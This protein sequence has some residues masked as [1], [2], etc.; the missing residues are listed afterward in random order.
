MRVFGVVRHPPKASSMYL[1]V[2]LVWVNYLRLPLRGRVDARNLATN[3]GRG[4][5]SPNGAGE[6]GFWSRDFSPPQNCP[7]MP[8]EVHFQKRLPREPV[9]MHSFHEF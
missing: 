8:I 6:S 2:D 5:S 1:H 3:S 7:E 4:I 9:L